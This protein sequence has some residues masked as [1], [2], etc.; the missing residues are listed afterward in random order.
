MPSSQPTL[1]DVAAIAGVNPA[2]AS[3][4]LNPDTRHLVRP[5]TARRVDAAARRLKYEPNRAARSLRTRTSH[6]V[7]III[8]DLTNPLF[9]GI[10]RGIEDALAPAGYTGL[11]TNTDGDITREQRM[12]E[13]LRARQVDGFI[14]AIAS[15]KSEVVETSLREDIPLVFVNR[16][17]ERAGVF[18][19]VPNDR[20]GI[21]QAVEHLV[22]LGHRHI[23]HVAGPQAMSTGRLRYSG[24]LEGMAAHGLPTPKKAIAHTSAFTEET[25][26]HATR[27]VLDAYPQCTAIVAANDLLALGA[28]AVLDERG[29]CC[30]DDVSIVG[31]ND[32]PFADR[33]ATPLTTIR[34]PLYDLGQRSAEL[35]LERLRGDHIE[36]R[37]VLLETS[38]V[39]RRSTAPPRSDVLVDA[40]GSRRPQKSRR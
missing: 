26:E 1:R 9:P 18:A 31:F 6:S 29:L 39:A 2:T 28:M 5:E 7:G 34:V 20:R 10:V 27:T 40:A 21:H 37:T 24:F 8:P 33:F 35:L 11:L 15:D 3:R 4:V 30:P 19:V 25:G 23:A 38:L 36:P 22:D 16:M 17:I 12:F 14:M 32:M 13:T